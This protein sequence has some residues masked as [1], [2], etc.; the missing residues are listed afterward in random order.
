[1]TAGIRRH[2][3]VSNAGEGDAKT[4]FAS[5]PALDGSFLFGD[6]ARDLGSSDDF[7]PSVFDGGNR[8]GN[9]N[10]LAVFAP[11]DGPEVF[12]PFS[13]SNPGEKA[14]HFLQSIGRN[15]NGNRLP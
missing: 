14:L 5:A 15:Q 3:C 8:Q 2:H 7:A 11:S 4:L 12:N 1:M 9:V 13:A 6:I 10:M